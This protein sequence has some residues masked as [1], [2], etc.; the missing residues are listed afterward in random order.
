MPHEAT[1]SG[2]KA[3]LRA[4][5]TAL[6][7]ELKLH[8]ERIRIC[9]VNPGPVATGFFGEDL[10][11]VPDLVF[12]QPMSTAEEISAAVLRCIETGEQEIDV[13]RLSGS[14]RRSA[15]SRRSSSRRSGRRWRSAA[16]ATRNAISPSSK[17]DRS[18][19]K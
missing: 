13:P 17:S 11:K 10:S 6:D 5:A 19:C 18:V 9:T 8:G 4:F 7:L 3:G 2:S 1:Y 14:W 15:I 12:S 16:R